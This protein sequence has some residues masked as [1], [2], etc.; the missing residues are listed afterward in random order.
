MSEIPEGS[1]ERQVSDRQSLVPIEELKRAFEFVEVSNPG[2]S[3]QLVQCI[4]AQLQKRYIVTN[5]SKNGR[6]ECENV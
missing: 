4:V 1:P 6:K 3:G 5:K 2:I